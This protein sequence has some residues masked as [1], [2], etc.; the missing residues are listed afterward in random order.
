ML[1]QPQTSTKTV[2]GIRRLLLLK[3]NPWNNTRSRRCAPIDWNG[4]SGIVGP[5]V[6]AGLSKEA[7]PLRGGNGDET[8]TGAGR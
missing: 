8:R 4:A 2:T 6:R 3:K 7:R 1:Y 5:Q